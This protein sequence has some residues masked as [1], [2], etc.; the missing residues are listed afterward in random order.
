M[1][2]LLIEFYLLYAWSKKYLHFFIVKRVDGIRI[3][4]YGTAFTQ[5][6]LKSTVH[7]TLWLYNYT[8]KDLEVA[9]G[10]ENVRFDIG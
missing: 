7:S 6:V 9:K 1:S 8:L 10:D 4:V 2:R 3:K 5:H